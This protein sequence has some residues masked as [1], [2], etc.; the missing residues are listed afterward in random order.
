[1][2]KRSSSSMHCHQW[3]APIWCRRQPAAAVPVRQLSTSLYLVPAHEHPQTYTSNIVVA[4]MWCASNKLQHQPSC[5]KKAMRVACRY[6]S[7][8]QAMKNQ[9]RAT[10]QCTATHWTGARG[11]WSKCGT[12]WI[13]RPRPCPPPAAGS[14]RPTGP[15]PAPPTWCPSRCSRRRRPAAS[16]APECC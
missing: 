9:A 10:L 3:R 7:I 5:P 4:S 11:G 13:W 6:N 14:R 2:P 8:N 16:A 15:A 12:G 1:M